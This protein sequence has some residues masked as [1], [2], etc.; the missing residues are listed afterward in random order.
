MVAGEVEVFEVA[1]GQHRLGHFL[2]GVVLEVQVANLVVPV[3]GGHFP[4]VVAGSLDNGDAVVGSEVEVGEV[5]DADV[6][7]LEFGEEVGVEGSDL[8]VGKVY[9]LQRFHVQVFHLG[10]LVA[11]QPQLDEV[12]DLQPTHLLQLVVL[13]VQDQ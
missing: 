8:V 4:E 2:D 12:V 1:A 7:L 13:H 9:F 5:V 10:D 6:D 3:E 11:L